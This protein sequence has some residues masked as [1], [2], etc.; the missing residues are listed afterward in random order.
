[1]PFNARLSYVS[2]LGL[3]RDMDHFWAPATESVSPVPILI[4][5]PFG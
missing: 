4:A 1:M 5:D 3:H 2:A